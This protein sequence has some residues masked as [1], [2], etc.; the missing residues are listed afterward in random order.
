MGNILRHGSQPFEFRI[1]RSDCWDF[2]LSLEP[3]GSDFREGLTE[4]C[5]YSYIDTNDPDCVW[6][7]DLVSKK[8]FTWEK[9]VN[10]G[11]E[12]KNIGLTGVD[13]GFIKYEK[14]RI[15]NE[16]FLELFLKSVHK[17]EEGDCRFKVRKVDGNNQILD[18]P[19]EMVYEDDIYCARLNGGFFQGFFQTD[20]YRVLPKNLN[21]S[22]VLEVMLKKHDFEKEGTTLNDRYP[23]NKGL[24][25]YIGTRAENKWWENFVVDDTFDESCNGYVV[26]GY[27]KEEYTDTNHLNDQYIKPF[28]DLYVSLEY[29]NDGYQLDKCE[30]KAECCCNSSKNKTLGSKPYYSGMP[31]FTYP[32]ALNV[33]EDNAVWFTPDGHLWVENERETMNRKGGG[34]WPVCKKKCKKCSEV[35]YFSDEYITPDYYE[36][37]CDCSIYFKED[38]LKEDVEIDVDEDILT[39]DGYSV[40]QPNI[41]QYRTDNKFILFDRTCNGVTV[42]TYEEGME[43]VLDEIMTPKMKNYF[44]LFN[45]TCNGYTV[46]TIDPLISYESKRYDVLA[47]IYRNALGFRIDDEGRI[48]YRYLVKDCENGGYKAEEEY[49]FEGAV[50]DDEWST[51]SVRIDSLGRGYSEC[52]EKVVATDKMTISIYVNG[53]LK[54]VSKELPLLNLRKLNDLYSKQEGVPYNIS[55]GGGTQG[56]CDT[57]GLNYRQPPKHALPL[58]KTFGGSFVGYVRKFRFYGC[59]VNFTDIV[60]NSVFDKTF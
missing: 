59:G 27:T 58:E 33:Y 13:N 45:R 11:V 47:D 40:K 46:N 4:D 20:T 6:F 12:L 26:D 43:V 38:Y 49:S 50:K 7:E 24:F 23:E 55:V 17:I 32:E 22:F 18:Y 16:K 30:E 31:V 48:G 14:D 35:H 15:T 51:V 3:Y 44:E 19:N 37:M 52:T 21:K 29:L 1:D 28:E 42:D 56:L 53:K 25:L 36:N 54:L 2:H 8:D 41:R 34:T 57:V 5:L 9:C 60:K 10:D 39:S